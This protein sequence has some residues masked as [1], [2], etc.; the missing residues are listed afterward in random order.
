MLTRTFVVP[1]RCIRAPTDASVMSSDP[2]IPVDAGLARASR[3]ARSR[4]NRSIDCSPTM[5]DRFAQ[6]SLAWDQWLVD[7]SKQRVTPRYRSRC[8]RTTRASATCRRGSP[9]SSRR[10]SQSVRGPT[11][12]AHRVAPAG[13]RR[14]RIVDGADVVPLIRSTQARVRS[15]AQQ[16]R[17][18]A[19][20]GATGRPLR[21]VV[22]IGIG[23]S[24]LG[25]RLVCDALAGPRAVNAP[26]A[27]VE[28]RF[29]R[30]SRTPDARA[31][32]VSIR[33]RRCSS[34]PRR[35]SL[36]P[37]RSP[38]RI[39]RANGSR[40]RWARHCNWRRISSPSPAMSKPRAHSASRAATFCR[41]GIGSAAA[42]RC[43][44]R[45]VCAIADALRLGRL[46]RTASPARPASTHISA[47]HRSSTT[48]RCCWRWSISGTRACWGI[49]NA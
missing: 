13:R 12:A 36:P 49:R 23:G 8:S 25:P 1:T 15:L 20:I 21:N 24:D 34:S 4:G 40:A 46:R 9:R 14:R 17:G 44:R 31:G 35:R 11:G 42:I 22:N 5:S 39:P 2:S 10:K 26:G 33:R 41:S 30:R 45:W 16:I 28:L 27:D 29:Q 32:R 3:D 6:L 47:T 38:T 18:G 43:G 7:L 48:C 37:K 19:R